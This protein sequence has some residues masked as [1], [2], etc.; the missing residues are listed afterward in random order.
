[1][2]SMSKT[3][4]RQETLS[5]GMIVYFHDHSNRYFGDYWR[6]HIEAVCPIPVR[7]LDFESGPEGEG[8]FNEA[9]ALLGSQ[10]DYTR[11]LER[12]GV[13]SDKLEETRRELID[14]FLIGAASYLENPAFAG[15][16]IRK[17]LAQKKGRGLWL[18]K[19]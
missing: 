2:T 11:T 16:W 17:A 5:N 6:I 12:M 9:R 19:G 10:A 7:R 15:K 14:A 18:M 1:M 4:F 3:P 8:A 13:E